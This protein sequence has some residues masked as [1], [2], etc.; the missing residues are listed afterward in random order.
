MAH[1][2]LQQE[3]ASTTFVKQKGRVRTVQ[4]NTMTKKLCSNKIT[5]KEFRLLSEF[6]MRDF[7]IWNVE[8]EPF[9][10]TKN[11]LQDLLNDSWQ[12]ENMSTVLRNSR[13]DSL[14]SSKHFVR[15]L[16][17]KGQLR[18]WKRRYFLRDFS[19]NSKL[20]IV[21]AFQ[22]LE[23]GSSFDT[24]TRRTEQR[25]KAARFR[26]VRCAV[27]TKTMHFCERKTKA[28]TK[29]PMRVEYIVNCLIS[30]IVKY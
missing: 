20:S 22:T 27:A 23:L 10:Q 5:K 25:W 14:R 13:T 8:N 29:R 3:L 2:S 6:L 16:L 12:V 26:D 19:W 30:S 7:L 18:S 24:A 4:N 15:D 9:V 17:G 21:S 28:G 1:P 11:F